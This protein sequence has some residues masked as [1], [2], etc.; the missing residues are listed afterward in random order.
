MRYYE[1]YPIS[2]IGRE[3]NYVSSITKCQ[4]K[5]KVKDVLYSKVRGIC[6]ESENGTIYE[7]SEITF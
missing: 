6:I 5:I 7:I 1:R 3:V 4:T 2:I